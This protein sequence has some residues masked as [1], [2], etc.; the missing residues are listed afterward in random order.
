MHLSI[1]FHISKHSSKFSFFIA[2]RNLVTHI[3]DVHILKNCPFENTFPAYERARSHM[4]L[5]M[6]STDDISVLPVLSALLFRLFIM[7][8][9]SVGSCPSLSNN[10]A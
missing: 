4:L 1:Y 9:V 2:F 7:V 8:R 6:E 3:L 5:D 10:L